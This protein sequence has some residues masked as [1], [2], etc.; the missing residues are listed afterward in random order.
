MYEITKLLNH[1]LF[2]S[3]KLNINALSVLPNFR[4]RKEQVGAS[5]IGQTAR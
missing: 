1:V 2:F 3:H 5:S 4:D